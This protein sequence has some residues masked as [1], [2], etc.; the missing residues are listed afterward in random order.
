M[1][2]HENK[3]L[4]REAVLAT[5]D[6]HGLSEIYVEKDYWATLALYEFFHSKMADQIVFKGGTALSKCYQLIERFSEDI[7]L[8]VIQKEEESPNQLKQRIRKLSKIV[9]KVKPEI[10]VVGLTNKRGNI[11]KTVHMYDKAFDGH[12]GQ[13]REQVVVEASWMGSSEPHKKMKINSYIGE[14]MESTGQDALIRQYDMGPFR[15]LILS[16]L[17]TFCEK[18]MSLVRFSRSDNPIM[19]L[20]NKI[21]HVYDIHKMLKD[22]EIRQFFDSKEFDEM[23]LKVGNDDMVAYKN[24]NAWIR[25]HPATALIFDRP[26]ETW[27]KLRTEYLSNFKDLLTGELPAEAGVIKTLKDVSSRMKNI[28]WEINSV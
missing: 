6:S 13:V 28:K 4:F 9:G 23:L 19:D 11:R 12:F 18:I 15:I 17:R 8:V 21:R 25:H 2:L 26:S 3:E 7:D 1:N 16:K 27:E 24:N 14:M 22:P 5:R 10:E 20:R